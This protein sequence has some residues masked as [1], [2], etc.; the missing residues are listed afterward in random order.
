[1]RILGLQIVTFF[2]IG[3]SYV[4][5]DRALH[6][7]F[8]LWNGLVMILITKSDN[9]EQNNNFVFVM[10]ENCIFSEDNTDVLNIMCL[11]FRLERAK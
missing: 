8:S 4:P 10:Q 2:F 1:L 9:S 11:N 5:E 6:S 3:R 7:A